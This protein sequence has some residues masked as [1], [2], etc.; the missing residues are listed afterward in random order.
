MTQFLEFSSP[1]S[2]AWDRLGTS[3][4]NEKYAW[5]LTLASSFAFSII[6][7][8]NLREAAFDALAGGEVAADVAN[9]SL[10]RHSPHPRCLAISPLYAVP[11]AMSFWVNQ[12]VI[13]PR[14]Y[15]GGLILERGSLLCAAPSFGGK[16]RG[17]AGSRIAGG[18]TTKTKG[19]MDAK[20]EN[21]TKLRLLQEDRENNHNHTVDIL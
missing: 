17:E 14:W 10:I 21:Y 5:T 11:R 13:L 9:R 16:V 7:A 6:N 1:R 2:R 20:P 19:Q 15:S 3:F 12:S 4:R 18:G 8:S